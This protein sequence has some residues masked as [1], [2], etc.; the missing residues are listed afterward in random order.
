MREIKSAYF[1]LMAEFETGKDVEFD[2]FIDYITREEIK[3]SAILTTESVDEDYE[4]ENSK[5]TQDASKNL[6]TKEYARF[7]DYMKR[8]KA[9][10][11]KEKLTDSEAASLEFV[12]GKSDEYYNMLK[13]MKVQTYETN[14][15]VELKTGMFDLT[16]DDF[17]IKDVTETKKRF[18]EAQANGSVMWKDIISFKTEALIV[19]GIYNPYS[20]ELNRQPL[21]DATR[22]MIKEMYK[23]ENLDGS[24][25]T[26]AEIHYNTNHFHI[27]LATVETKNTRR[28]IEVNGELEARGMRKLS[29]LDSMK[30]VLANQIFD[31]SYE[32]EKISELRDHLRYVS[33][34]KLH[35][36]KAERGLE[37]LDQ[38]KQFLPKNK[39]DWNMKTLSKDEA[40]YQAMV[41]LIDTM[42]KHDPKFLA[43]K[44]LA[45]KESE[46][47]NLMYGSLANHQNDFY[48]GRMHSKGDGIYYRLGNSILQELRQSE[49]EKMKAKK[50]FESISTFQNLHEYKNQNFQPSGF[51]KVRRTLSGTKYHF[52][53]IERKT[54]NEFEV[55]A[56]EHDQLQ[57]EIEWARKRQE[58]E[59]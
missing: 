4:F 56:A 17:S 28:M 33:K 49:F 47:R 58:F 24:A 20:N 14:P 6:K 16:K 15:S 46:H 32:L 35:R 22:K 13:E 1:T 52:D 19:S 29:S 37:Q 26:V 10:E 5:I 42:M 54:K 12:S 7:L 38:L 27:H 45:R 39:S 57:H 8:K 30:S 50:E 36:I 9:L 34:E 23:R 25:I 40:G 2:G 43:Y 21:I 44:N 59:M 51:E 3:E 48:E 41:D 55:I 53:R 18:K 31:R 11:K